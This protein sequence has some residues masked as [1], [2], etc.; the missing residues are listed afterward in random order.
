MGTG[1]AVNAAR[2]AVGEYDGDIAVLFADTPLISSETLNAVFDELEQSDVAVLGFEAKD[3]GAYGRL[4]EKDGS[5]EKIVEAKEASPEELVVTLCNSGVLAANSSDLYIALESVTN[6]NAKGEYYLTDVIEIM[7]QSGKRASVVRG[8]EGEMLGVNSR[9]DLAAANVAFQTKARQSA[10]ERGVTLNDPD[11][12]FFSYN[13]IVEQDAVIGEHVVFGPGVTVKS[14]ATIQPFC[15]V[16]GAIIREGAS[17]GPFARIRPGAD[18]G[19]NSFIGNFVE[20]KKTR[21]GAGSKASHLT[22]L[23]DTEIGEGT[24][25]G[26]GTV[27]CNYDGF[28]KHKTTIGDGVFIGTHTSLVAPVTVHDGAFT[29]TGA[30]VTKDVP[31]DSL[32]IARSDQVNKEGWAARFRAAMT[33]R[34]QSK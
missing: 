4:I 14:G 23:G 28:F 3:P 26:A 33:K 30:V 6:D 18:L 10:L 19:E 2:D 25:V 8:D 22:Y 34:K 31:K 11:T 1:H 12:I 29:A 7:R 20:V 27:T 24:N 13:T 9:V 5:L 17:V 16:E 21:L 15:H 32:A